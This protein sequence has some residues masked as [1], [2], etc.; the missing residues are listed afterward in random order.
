[1]NL[2]PIE[3]TSQVKR[4]AA[5]LLLTMAV[6]FAA[7]VVLQSL[8]LGYWATLLVGAGRAIAEAGMV[9]GIADWFAVTALFRVPVRLP[10]GLL[11]K[12]TAII[13]NNKDRIGDLLAEF[14]CENFLVQP[15]IEKQML[16]LDVAAAMARW[17]TDPPE[18]GG[19]RFR[20]Q[21]SSL[22]AQMLRALDP[23]QLGGLLKGAIAERVKAARLSPLAGQLLTAAM[24][25][26]RHEPVLDAAIHRAARALED[27]ELLIRAK[28]SEGSG[29]LLRFVRADRVFGNKVIDFLTDLFRAMAADPEHPLRIKVGEEL[30]RFAW[31][32]RYDPATRDRVERLKAELIDN[33]AMQRWLDG[34]WEQAREMLIVIASDP[35]A[36][37]AG[38]VGDVLRQLG[39]TLTRN[40]S[41]T[42][43]L[44]LFAQ[45]ALT[46][47]ILDNSTWIARLFSNTV[48]SWDE[49]YISD[50]IEK[51]VGRDI[52]F[53][54]ING[55]VVGGLVGF[56]IYFTA[57]A[58]QW[59]V[60]LTQ[61]VSIDR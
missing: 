29:G 56:L 46:T 36:A 53:I 13:P 16:Q 60:W 49:K 8:A 3:T 1:M 31:N 40:R 25:D 55:A 43:A 2:F 28:I 45:N 33:P 24:K 7:M 26:G 48:K 57:L 44:N 30:D 35:E 14:L 21:A 18:A 17:L 10:F 51:A 15:I 11:S 54:R 41:L 42:E 6:V 12:H 50:V 20:S 52:Q 37:M 47:V 39:T 9:G 22:V 32:L 5:T 34:L 38:P 27:H 61:H 19:G 4:L 59:L 23:Q 58:I